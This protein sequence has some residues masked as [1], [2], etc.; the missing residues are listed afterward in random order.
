M[1]DAT[2]PQA[3]LYVAPDGDGA[4][5]GTLEQPFATLQ[6]ARRAVRALRPD[7]RDR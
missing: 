5:R 1:N 3:H 4:G 2:P 7:R 6:Q